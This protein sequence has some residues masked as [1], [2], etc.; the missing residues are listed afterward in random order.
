MVDTLEKPL[1]PTYQIPGLPPKQTTCTYS[2][3]YGG[4]C[5]V[6]FSANRNNARN[7]CKPCRDE[8]S[9]AQNGERIKITY[10]QN[11]I[12]VDRE[13][14]FNGGSGPDVNRPNIPDTPVQTPG[15]LVTKSRTGTCKYTC[16]QNGGCEVA[17]ETDAPY[18]GKIKGSCFPPDFGGECSGTPRHCEDCLPKCKGHIGDTLYDIVYWND[19][20][21]FSQFS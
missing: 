8:C 10:D 1:D 9:R 20:L 11:D 7:H 17:F 16:K 15:R 21:D 6:H 5:G 19:E 14:N 13:S 2:C 12:E 4:S 18:S 3:N